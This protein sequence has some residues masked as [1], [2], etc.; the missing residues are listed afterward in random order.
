[1][2]FIGATKTLKKWYEKNDFYIYRNCIVIGASGDVTRFFPYVN[3][4]LLASKIN[5]KLLEAARL[6]KERNVAQKEESVPIDRDVEY[7][8]VTEQIRDEAAYQAAKNP[9]TAAND[10][11]TD[12]EESEDERSSSSSSS[13]SS[14]G[15]E[16]N[17][18]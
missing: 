7:P 16:E 11:D 12:L 2:L 4:Y 18:R 3:F 5:F 10:S 14:G 15:E 8:S 6:W 9:E 13:E 17:E 1:M